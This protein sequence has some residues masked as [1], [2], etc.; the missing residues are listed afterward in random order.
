M[1]AVY[2]AEKAG[3]RKQRLVDEDVYFFFLFPPYRSK[4]KCLMQ[5]INNKF[6]LMTLY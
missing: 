5:T 4:K 2:L 3:S 1:H 6:V